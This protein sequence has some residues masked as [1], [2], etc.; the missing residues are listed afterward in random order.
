MKK[1]VGKSFL[2]VCLSMLIGVGLL[3]SCYQKPHRHLATYHVLKH[4][5]ADSLLFSS[6]H[7]Y[8]NNYNFIVKSDTL[9]LFKQQPEEIVS[10]LMIDSLIIKRHEHVV[11]ADIRMIPT[12]TIDSVWV[13]L[14]SDQHTF[15]WIHESQ[16]L[17]KVVPSD[18]IS[19]FIS[20]FSDTHLLIFLIIISLIAVAYW[21]HLVQ[22][23]NAYIVHFRDIQSFYPT[24]LCLIVAASATLYASM[25]MFVPELWKQ[26]YFHPTLNPFSVHFP[27]SLFLMSV[28]AMLIVGLAV[29]DD[30]RHSL[31]FSDA[32]MYLGGVVA[33][34]A[35][36]Y[37]IFGLSTLYFIGYPLL[38]L[39]FYFSIR[40]YF[41]HARRTFICG[42]CGEEISHKGRCEHCGAMNV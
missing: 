9:V 28:W 38:I 23:E 4:K 24:L 40:L 22:K 21:L 34:C 12:D 2:W 19:Q 16:M 5:Q 33:V 13:Q 31:P 11:V 18:P 3:S 39:Y 17:P 42:N 14:A 36:N 10:G 30:V 26:F 8:S 37:I 27:L 15:G 32:V 41:K 20:I 25:Q 6:K 1:L 35:V 7:H 29:V